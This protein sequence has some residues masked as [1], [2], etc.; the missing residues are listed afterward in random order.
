MLWKFDQGQSEYIRAD[1]GGILCNKTKV[2]VTVELA[3]EDKPQ[4]P[5]LVTD[6]FVPQTTI[7]GN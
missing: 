5:V 1:I 3:I 4:P 7:F 6:M 2:K